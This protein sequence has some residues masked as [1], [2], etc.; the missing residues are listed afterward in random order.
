[1]ASWRMR[2]TALLVPFGLSLLSGCGPE[3]ARLWGPPERVLPLPAGLRV[4]FNHREGHRYR[5]P[6]S[7]RWRQGDDMEAMVV[8]AI[9]AARREVLV[10]VQELSLPGV[11]EALIERRRQGVDVRVVMENTYSTPWSQQH[12][13]DLTPHQR[14]RHAQLRALGQPDAVALLLQARVPLLDDTADGS[15][16]SGLMHHKFLVV[17]RRV[18][19][20][21]SANFSPS[22]VHGDPDDSRTRGNVNHLLR[23]DSAPLAALFAE[24]FL[25]MWGDG[26][27]GAPDSR[28]GQA[29]DS[30]PAR[31]VLVGETPVEVLFAPHRRSD[32][33]HGLHWLAERLVAVRRHL[34]LS[35]F[36]FSAQSL[37]DTL[38]TLP[39]RGV[40]IRLLADPGFASR[41][42]S[43]V[44]DVLGVSRADGTCLLE[45]DNTVWQRPLEGVG[46][47]R[48]A[49]G[50]KLHHKFAVIDNRSVIT[51]SFNWSPSAA[52]QNDETLLLIESPQLAAH[53][54]REMDRLWRGAELG[55][56]GRM[57]R[58]VA[59]SR[60]RC[61][62]GR[63]RPSAR[64]ASRDAIASSVTDLHPL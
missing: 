63:A 58:G 17:D 53:F 49:G 11:A 62:R 42:F 47:P 20:T 12:I 57:E 56:S 2:A 13:A 43:E 34:D 46:T 14:H 31:R 6:V 5:S 16:G 64:Q 37:A 4:A 51:G 50:D 22:C 9:G 19:V 41:P 10:A 21:G 48:L 23:F 59:R 24:E 8:E 26:P 29:K 18:V 1:M 45:A 15:A 27:G 25:R 3:P 28:F 52:H 55:V 40:A 61:G 32:P 44:L 30:G 38:A 33:H 35:L 60:Q 54:T 36:V 7:G 39:P